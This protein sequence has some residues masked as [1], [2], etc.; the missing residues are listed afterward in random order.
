MLTNNKIINQVRDGVGTRLLEAASTVT[1]SWLGLVA[2]DIAFSSTCD[3][4]GRIPF[5][6][7]KMTSQAR[8]RLK[9]V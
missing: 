5:D 9:A 2:Y 3:D 6:D 8:A 4:G 7:V 1:S